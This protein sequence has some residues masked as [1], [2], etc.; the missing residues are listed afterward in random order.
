M[1][2]A[3][4]LSVFTATTDVGVISVATAQTSTPLKF[5]ITIKDGKSDTDSIRVTQ[6]EQVEIT[7]TSDQAAEL[8]L[9]GYDLTAQIEPGVPTA[10]S[11][12]AR[13]AGRFPVEAHR[14]GPVAKGRRHPG[15]LFYVE[16][17]PP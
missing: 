3:D 9:H 6:G 7:L 8:H 12:D 2:M 13:I 10:L 11:F 14:M 16:V 4:S 1:V 17:Y 5:S 15:A